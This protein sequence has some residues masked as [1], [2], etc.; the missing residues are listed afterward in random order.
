MPHPQKSASPSSYLYYRHAF[1]IRIM[2]WVNVISLTILLMS[3]LNI[4]NAHPSLYW[5]KSSYTGVPPLF[6]IIGKEDDQG[7]VIGITRILGHEFTTTGMLGASS[8]SDGEI[9]KRGFPSWITIPD[10]YWL[11]MAR[12]WHMFFA[13]LLV[14]NGLCYVS[15]S[16]F[17]RHLT[18]DI[19]PTWQELRRIGKAVVDHLQFRHPTGNAAKEYNV[20]QKLAYLAVIVLLLPLIILEGFGM[21]PGLNALLPG[22]LD[23]LGGRQSAR[24]FHFVLAWVLVCFTFVHLFEIFVSGLWNNLRSMVT[25]RYRITSEEEHEQEQ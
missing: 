17:S 8:N 14:I 25:G 18:R 22:W 24:T 19:V 13:W 4:F 6:E 2:H 15:Y 16:L 7:E 21:S 9:M 3:G 11:S 23:L 10:K 1:P 12:R 20:I 5:G